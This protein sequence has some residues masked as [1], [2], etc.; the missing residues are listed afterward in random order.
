MTK[1]TKEA[2]ITEI[3]RD[4]REMALADHRAKRKPVYNPAPDE[5]A[6]APFLHLTR[7]QHS[8]LMERERMR[9][10]AEDIRGNKARAKEAKAAWQA[11]KKG[12]EARDRLAAHR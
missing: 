5:K 11:A 3:E 7:F 4:L 10:E 1:R 12:L 8:K 2:E 6:V 9:Y